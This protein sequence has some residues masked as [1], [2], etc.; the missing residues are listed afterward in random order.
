MNDLE[1]YSLDAE[2]M[3]EKRTVYSRAIQA[4]A[5]CC[6]CPM[7]LPRWLVVTLLSASALALL[8]AGAWWWVTWPERT[9]A[10]FKSLLKDGKFHEANAMLNGPPRERRASNEDRRPVNLPTKVAVSF[11]KVVV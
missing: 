3:G 5:K 7:K 11:A 9:L 4:T 10:L 6:D 1:Y 8:G 2:L